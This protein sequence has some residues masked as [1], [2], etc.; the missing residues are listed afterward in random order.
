MTEINMMMTKVHIV[1]LTNPYH[2]A[3][4]YEKLGIAKWGHFSI[5]KGELGQINT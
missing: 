2:S 3:T 1:V 4:D 5:N